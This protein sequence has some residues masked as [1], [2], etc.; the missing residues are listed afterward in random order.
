MNICKET[1]SIFI[2]FITFFNCV[3][4]AEPILDPNLLDKQ[5]EQNLIH[6]NS[7]GKLINVSEGIHDKIAISVHGINASPSTLASIMSKRIEQN[8]DTY[9]FA[10]DNEFRRLSHSSNDFASELLVLLQ[11]KPNATVLIDAH[12]MGARMVLVALGRLQK[13]NSF[14]DNRIIFNLIAPPLSGYESANSAIRA[15]AI[16]QKLIKNLRPSMDM[17]TQSLFQKELDIVRLK[18][19][20]SLKIFFAEDDKTAP[21]DAKSYILSQKLNA[22]FSVVENKNHDTILNSIP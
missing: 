2:L 6:K 11:N 5:W 12:S 8:F 1:M 10:W 4:Y 17:G 16:A 15:P 22:H 3:S 7:P 13:N 9:T 19:N 14:L 20:F 21:L 18:S